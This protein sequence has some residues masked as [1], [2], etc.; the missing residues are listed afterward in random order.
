[1][2][3]YKVKALATHLSTRTYGLL[4]FVAHKDKFMVEG[5]YNKIYQAYNFPELETT[6]DQLT[7]RNFSRLLQKVIQRAESDKL[8]ANIRS[9]CKA[10]LAPDSK[11]ETFAEFKKAIEDHQKKADTPIKSEYHTILLHY[12]EQSE[13]TLKTYS[14]VDEDWRT[15]LN[16]LSIYLRFCVVIVMLPDSVLL[17][18]QGTKRRFKT[19]KTISTIASYYGWFEQALNKILLPMFTVLQTT[20]K[21]TKPIDHMLIYLYG[22]LYVTPLKQQLFNQTPASAEG[23]AADANVHNLPALEHFRCNY[24]FPLTEGGKPNPFTQLFAKTYPQA[25]ADIPFSINITKNVHAGSDGVIMNIFG[26][27]GAD[28]GI[29]LAASA[30]QTKKLANGESAQQAVINK[31]KRS[32]TA[33]LNLQLGDNAYD[34]GVHAS[35]Q[36]QYFNHNLINYGLNTLGEFIPNFVAL[37]NHDYGLWSNYK[38]TSIVDRDTMA[39][40]LTRAQWQI[41]HSYIAN[42]HWHMPNH[43]YLLIHEYFITIVIDS[44]NIMFDKAQQ[45]WIVKTLNIIQENP[46]LSNKHLIWA[47]H[48]PPVYIGKR[49]AKDCE[50]EKHREALNKW[51]PGLNATPVLWNGREFTQ[52]A[53]YTKHEMHKYNNIGKFLL[54]FIQLNNLKVDLWLAAHEH[55]T[56]IHNISLKLANESVIKFSQIISGGGGAELSGLK[57]EFLPGEEKN[58]I[59][60]LPGVQAV[61][62]ILVAQAYAYIALQISRETIRYQACSPQGKSITDKNYLQEGD[63]GD[64]DLTIHTGSLNS[65]FQPL[66][67]VC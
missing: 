59:E 45:Q 14:T 63:K 4:S 19:D 27:H 50:W 35:N 30:H 62:A 11:S 23:A 52:I 17:P 33:Q 9:A 20:N 22:C 25:I 56:A 65:P 8:R 6:L 67:P 3:D 26:C 10:Y 53:P 1:M 38:M 44:N 51:I 58:P 5:D 47:S 2:A 60:T 28:C 40:G 37:G 43:Y 66:C 18:P 29:S 16:L 7:R 39:D 46:D 41:L 48:H 34:N 24:F 21:L 15:L 36:Q 54:A 12:I 13:N 31:S 32:A 64:A 61:T 57:N 42:D 55:V 49:A